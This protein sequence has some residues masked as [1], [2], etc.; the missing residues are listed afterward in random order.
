MNGNYGEEYSFWYKTLRDDQKGELAHE[1]N[2]EENGITRSMTTWSS[3]LSTGKQNGIDSHGPCTRGPRT[4]SPPDTHT[5]NQHTHL[6]VN[7]WEFTSLRPE[8]L[9]K[10]QVSQTTTD[11]LCLN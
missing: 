5:S 1:T 9:T 3:S 10:L 8:S 7:A 2:H 11:L 6:Y 4:R